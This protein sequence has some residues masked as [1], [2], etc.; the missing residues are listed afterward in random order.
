MNQY[1]QLQGTSKMLCLHSCIRWTRKDKFPKY[2]A[3]LSQYVRSHRSSWPWCSDLD[4]SDL[5]KKAFPAGRDQRETW[6]KVHYSAQTSC[7]DCRVPDENQFVCQTWSNET[8]LKIWYHIRLHSTVRNKEAQSRV[9]CSSS[10]LLHNLVNTDRSF[11]NHAAQQSH[12]GNLYFLLQSKHTIQ[13]S[14][15]CV[16]GVYCVHCTKH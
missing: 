11:Y 5:K 8:L 4:F 7:H 6:T 13:N 16:I 2:L 15:Y 10:H 14:E 1:F 12:T 3:L 9:L